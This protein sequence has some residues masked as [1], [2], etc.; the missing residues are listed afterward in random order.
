MDGFGDLTRE[1]DSLCVGV[2]DD[3]GEHLGMVAVSSSTGIGGR[4]DAV[5]QAVDR[6]MNDANKMMRWN[7][8]LQ[9]QFLFVCL[10]KV[11]DLHNLAE[12]T[13]RFRTSESGRLCPQISSLLRTVPRNL[14][15]TAMGGT[16]RTRSVS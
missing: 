16:I 12:R 1:I 9:V 15:A 13:K 8:A 2:N 6:F 11:G 14:G 5:I 4:K 10:I 3:F 7:V